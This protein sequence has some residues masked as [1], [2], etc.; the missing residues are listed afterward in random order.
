MDDLTCDFDALPRERLPLP[1]DPWL[2]RRMLSFGASEI[3]ALMLALGEEQPDETTPAYTIEAAKRLF[4]LKAGLR[5][6]E[7]ENA[8]TDAGKEAEHELLEAWSRD[9]FSRW[10]RAVHASVVPASWFPLVDRFCPRLS[11]TP[12]AWCVGGDT[13]VQIKTDVAGDL[14][15]VTRGFYLQTQG[16]MGVLGMRRTAL[17]YGPGWACTW[18]KRARRAPI[19]WPV[20]RDDE[21]IE[22]IRSACRRGWKR[23]EQIWQDNGG[24]R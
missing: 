12:D 10:P 11:C 20:E 6:P 1:T 21:C 19:A 23:V 9:P 18:D 4:G 13:N 3:H 2:V 22:S 17:L 14:T 16:E 15:G 5:L 8:V 7:R 24:R